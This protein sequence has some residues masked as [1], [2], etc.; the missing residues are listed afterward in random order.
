MKILV[1]EDN[2]DFSALLTV[3]IKM[4]IKDADISYAETCSDAIPKIE[5]A[6]L[7]IS[8]FNFPTGGFPAILPVLQ[9]ENRPFILQSSCPS[10]VKLYDSNLQV[11]SL[12]KNQLFTCNLID[13]LK[14]LNNRFISTGH[15]RP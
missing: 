7:I 15:I 4:A 12:C 6:D 11:A 3:I 10:C 2:K 13:L 8:D 5:Y 14:E 9:K 1:V